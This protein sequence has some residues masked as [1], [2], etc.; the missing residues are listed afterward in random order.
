MYAF[1]VLFCIK[2]N[3]A[4]KNNIEFLLSCHSTNQIN[5]T[6]LQINLIIK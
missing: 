1:Y 3:N 5:T 4:K 2:L 6:Y